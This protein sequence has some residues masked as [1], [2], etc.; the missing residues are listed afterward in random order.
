MLLTKGREMMMS[1]AG[2][3]D[4]LTNKKGQALIKFGPSV[5]DSNQA[6]LAR[7]IEAA[8]VF[9]ALHYCAS[10]IVFRPRYRVSMRALSL[11]CPCI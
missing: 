4:N 8:S 11:V 2:D 7:T 6:V 10:F 3:I 9:P 1:N 5:V